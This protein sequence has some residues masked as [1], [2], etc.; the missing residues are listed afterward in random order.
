MQFLYYWVGLGLAA[1]AIFAGVTEGGW[2][3]LGTAILLPVALAIF[4]ADRLV[5]AKRPER[6]GSRVMNTTRES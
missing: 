3:W 5:A 4:F 2:M 6:A 1:V